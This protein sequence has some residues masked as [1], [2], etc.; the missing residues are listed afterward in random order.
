[1]AAGGVPVPSEAIEVVRKALA[2]RKPIAA[3]NSAV[4]IL[5][6]A[7]ALKGMHFAIEADLASSVVGGAYSGIGVV[8]D[9]NIVTSRAPVL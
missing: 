6:Q 9:G 3:Q 7:G 5:N 2:L 4:Q 1:M 8:Q